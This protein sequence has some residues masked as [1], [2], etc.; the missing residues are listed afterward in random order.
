MCNSDSIFRITEYAKYEVRLRIRNLDIE[1]MLN[2]S[3]QNDLIDIFEE[4]FWTA[5]KGKLYVTF[6]AASDY[7]GHQLSSNPND[8]AGY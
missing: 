5:S 4:H 7:E 6:M 8:T 2:K 1:E 3:R